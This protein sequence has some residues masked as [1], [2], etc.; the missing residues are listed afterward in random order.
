MAKT[1]KQRWK[2]F[3]LT[4]ITL[5]YVTFACRLERYQEKLCRLAFEKKNV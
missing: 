1:K 2:L 3:I 5:A 4:L